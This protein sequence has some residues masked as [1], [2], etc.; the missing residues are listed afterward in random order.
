M[1]KIPP[2]QRA[3]DG[4]ALTGECA[5]MWCVFLMNEADM[6]DDVIA[7]D[8][9]KALYDMFKPKPG[10]P[11]AAAIYCHDLEEGIQQWIKS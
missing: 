5:H 1:N 11:M 8:T 4:H 9:Y 7:Y 2:I 10:V 3:Y 6:A